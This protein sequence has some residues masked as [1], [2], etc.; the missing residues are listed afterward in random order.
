MLWAAAGDERFALVIANQSGCGGASLNRRR[1]GETLHILSNV[2]RTWF[3]EACR[4]GPEDPDAVPVDQH[5][6]IALLA[7]RPV[8]VTSAVEDSGA[9]P[10][11]EFLAIHHAGPV[12]RL[13]GLDG[14]P[15]PMPQPDEP[16]IRDACGY[17]I[18]PGPHDI[19]PHDWEAHLAF[20]DHHLR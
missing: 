18:R 7:P 1:F 17:F 12:Y 20:A 3:C 9:D 5:E 2:R 6:L 14:M 15:Q 10:K 19:T 11:G 16:V 8:M 4:T 13:F